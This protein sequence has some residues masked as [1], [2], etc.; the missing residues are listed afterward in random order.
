MK[1]TCT[2]KMADTLLSVIT[3]LQQLDGAGVTELAIVDIISQNV[4]D[5]FKPVV[6]Y[7]VAKLYKP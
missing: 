7:P 5:L 3:N 4:D 6:K 2:V 1:P